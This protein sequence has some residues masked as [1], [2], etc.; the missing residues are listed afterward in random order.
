MNTDGQGQG[1]KSKWWEIQISHPTFLPLLK[2][3]S[4]TKYLCDG[5]NLLKPQRFG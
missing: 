5:L 2:K 1:Q 3:K 4:H